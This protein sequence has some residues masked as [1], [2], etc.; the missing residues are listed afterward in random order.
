MC[1]EPGNLQFSRRRSQ[2]QISCGRSRTKRDCSL[3][4]AG[5]EMRA[6]LAGNSFEVR[7]PMSLTSN[8]QM[9]A[10]RHSHSQRECEAEELLVCVA[11]EFGL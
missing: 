3:C 10:A 9:P 1:A 8:K 4:S 6:G 5:T 2:R 7:K 11:I